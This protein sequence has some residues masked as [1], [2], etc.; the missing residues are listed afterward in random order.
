MKKIW[1]ALLM[2]LLWPQLLHAEITTREVTYNAGDV[3][4]KGYFAYDSSIEGKR[5][6][7][8]VVHEWWG[9]NEYARM[10]AR[11]LAELGYAALAVDMY[12]D[13]KVAEH[14][15]EAGEFAAEVNNHMD[16]AKARFQAALEALHQQPVVDAGHTAAI[17]YCSG[18]GMLLNLIRTGLDIEAVVTFHANLKPKVPAGDHEIKTSVLVCTGEADKFIPAEDV[19]A[20]REEMKAAGADVEILTYK[21]ATH[22]FTNPDADRLAEEF[23]LPFRYSPEADRESWEDMRVFLKKIFRNK[24]LAAFI[25]SPQ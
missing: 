20:F 3:V 1:I 2:G 16:V 12:G 9:L 8:L 22:S 13:G 21:D 18:G 11:M 17:G 7:V 19:E 15:K 6:G 10:R 5:P 14:P 25:H 23:G 24:R 4:M